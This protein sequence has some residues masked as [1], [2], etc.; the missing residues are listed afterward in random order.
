MY[1]PSLSVSP[2]APVFGEK[3]VPLPENESRFTG[4]A[5]TVAAAIATIARDRENCMLTS[6][7]SA[8][9]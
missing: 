2:Q 7:N 6:R 5:E 1:E 9:C 3:K 4:I 8:C